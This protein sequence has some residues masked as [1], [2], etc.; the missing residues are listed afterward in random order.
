[1][2][3]YYK[4]DSVEKNKEDKFVTLINLKSFPN[5]VTSHLPNKI[6]VNKKYLNKK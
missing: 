4:L 3:K 6:T 2:L 5:D 1:M